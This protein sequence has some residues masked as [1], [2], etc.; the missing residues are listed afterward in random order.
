MDTQIQKLEQIK[1]NL[2]AQARKKFNQLNF[3]NIRNGTDGIDDRLENAKIM[4]EKA[5]PILNGTSDE[6]VDILNSEEYTS[7]DNN[8]LERMRDGL[9]NELQDLLFEISNQ[10]LV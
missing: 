1:T 5:A 10:Y 4:E 8:T 2:V 6:F 3:R 9:N 7:I